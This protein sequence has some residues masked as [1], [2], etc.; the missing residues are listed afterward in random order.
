M[1]SSTKYSFAKEA[2]K[3]SISNAIKKGK[4]PFTGRRFTKSQ[5]AEIKKLRKG[6]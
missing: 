6:L 4:N 5:L 3:K 2:I 1:K